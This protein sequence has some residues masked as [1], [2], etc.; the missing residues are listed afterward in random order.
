MEMPNPTWR[1]P[2]LHGYP[3]PA[4]PV[5]EQPLLASHRRSQSLSPPGTDEGDTGN[6]HLLFLI[7][8]WEGEDSFWKL[9]REGK[10]KAMP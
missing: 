1:C 9:S 8:L 3:H 2:I 6:Q 5:L 7:G 4:A 10:G